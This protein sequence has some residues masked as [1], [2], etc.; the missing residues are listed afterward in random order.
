MILRP[1]R[2]ASYGT[3]FLFALLLAT[4]A[5]AAG[6]ADQTTPA[7]PPVDWKALTPQIQEVLGDTYN[8]CNRYSRITDL[9]QS[10]DITGDGVLTAIVAY[11]RTDAYTSNVALMRIEEGKPVL[12]RFRDAKGKPFHPTFQTGATIKS[13]E[14]VKLL[15]ARQAVY[16]IQWHIDKAMKMDNCA[17]QAYVWTPANGTFDENAAVSKEIGSSEC[18]R[19]AKQLE[20]QTSQF[21][22]PKKHHVW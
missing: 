6:Q 10:G 3:L 2:M 19:L 18:A 4:V 21:A 16:D 13:G 14:G 5:G 1:T 12:A 15:R 7:P 8:M 11:C 22:Q 17:V 20:D 9:I